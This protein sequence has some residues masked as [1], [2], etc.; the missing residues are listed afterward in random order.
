MRRTPLRRV[1]R[2]QTR[3]NREIA[4]WSKAV[5]ERDGRCVGPERGLPGVCWGELHA[6]HVN[7][8]RRDNRLENGVT[9]CTW[10]H[11][12]GGRD[13]VHGNPALAFKL[14]LLKRKNT[15]EVTR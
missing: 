1:S 11:V 14:G 6:H 9:L 2:K 3:L 5:R 15:E 10:H 8:D 13:S 7:R 4:A 12:W